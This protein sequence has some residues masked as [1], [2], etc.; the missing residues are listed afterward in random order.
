MA[1]LV[2]L[3]PEE[4]E[5]DRELENI[6]YTTLLSQLSGKAGDIL[7]SEVY[8]RYRQTKVNFYNCDLYTIPDKLT[9]DQPLCLEEIPIA[10]YDCWLS[11]DKLLNN[12]YDPIEEF[13]KM[14]LKIQ[15]NSKQWSWIAPVKILYLVDDEVWPE[16]KKHTCNFDGNINQYLQ[17]LVRQNNKL[18]IRQY[19]NELC[20][21]IND[22][23]FFFTIKSKLVQVPYI[24]DSSKCHNAI[25]SIYSCSTNNS[26]HSIKKFKG[27][28]PFSIKCYYQYYKDARTPF[29]DRIEGIWYDKT[30][31]YFNR[32]T[33]VESLFLITK[34]GFY[35]PVKEIL[36]SNKEDYSDKTE[37]TQPYSLFLSGALKMTFC[38]AYTENVENSLGYLYKLLSDSKITVL[39][40]E[41][42]STYE[43]LYSLPYYNWI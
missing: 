37:L 4:I 13:S 5:R 28:I 25:I 15:S 27:C 21:Y 23:S 43:F 42:N 18:T 20:R 32:K 31:P 8:N 9:C 16:L 6:R 36:N 11:K 3:S 24:Q 41:R 14:Y 34:F 19:V 17:D 40:D 26:R 30:I 22:N 12:D 29:E 2:A 35:I 38:Y 10:F 33:W 39:K 1:G 7:F